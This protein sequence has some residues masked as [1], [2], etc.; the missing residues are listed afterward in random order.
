[1]GKF[2]LNG[3]IILTFIT[4]SFNV[5]AAE[6]QKFNLTADHGPELRSADFPIRYKFEKETNRRWEDTTYS[7]REAFLTDWHTQQHL[8][9]LA[10]EKKEKEE[11]KVLKQANKE[12]QDILKEKNRKITRKKDKE[13]RRIKAQRDEKRLFEKKIKDE[14]KRIKKLRDKQKSR[15]KRLGK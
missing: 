15:T 8:Q 12:K 9:R 6:N 4:L 14:K 11:A 2:I 13:E 7:Q 1:M 10:L 3:C 5:W